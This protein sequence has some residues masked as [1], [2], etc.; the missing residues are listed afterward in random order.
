MKIPLVTRNKI[1][2][3]VALASILML[4][5]CHSSDGG[6]AS[7]MTSFSA[8]AS[9]SATPQLFT[10][11]EDQMSHVQVVTIAPTTLKRTLRLTGAVAYNAFNTTPVI[12]QVGGPV[13]RI[14]VVPGVHVKAGQPMLEVSSPDYSQLLNAYLKASDSFRLTD[15]NYARAQD[16][17]QHH[18]NAERDLE[19]AESDRNQAQADLNA[20]EQGLKILG[21]KNPAGLAKAPSSAQIPVLA[22]ISGEVVDRLVSP[23]QVVQAGQTQAFTISDLSTVWVLANVYQADLAYVH[24]GDEAVAQTDAYPGS[25]HGRISYVSPAVD[26][27]TRTLQV[28]VVV[29]NPGEKLKKDMYCTVSVTA[30]S[31][32]NVVVVPNASVLRDDNNEP[33]VYVAS[34][35]NQFGRRDVQLGDSQNGQTQILKGISVG[36][37]VVGDGSLFLQFANSLQH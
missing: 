37:R 32:A 23:G 31:I 6:Q 28:R 19:Q 11:P 36:E 24:S 9:K 22:P 12:T 13:S 21:I 20:A 35:A 5:G 26:P 34:G 16:L 25:F 27:T 17:F 30:G 1:P 10:I 15:K 14:L 7:Q 29:D 3:A 2:S 18:A 8:N 33:F 4:T